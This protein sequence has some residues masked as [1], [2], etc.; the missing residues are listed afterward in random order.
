MTTKRHIWRKKHRNQAVVIYTPEHYAAKADNLA[1]I[2][3]KQS[4][5]DDAADSWPSHDLSNASY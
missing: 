2:V 1:A 3:Y 5:T 4:L